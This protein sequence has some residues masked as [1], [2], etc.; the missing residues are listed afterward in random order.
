MKKILIAAAVA[1]SL[2]LAACVSTSATMLAGG[3]VMAATDPT[4]VTIYRTAAQV[5]GTYREIALLDS[6][7]DSMG[8]NP[9]QMYTSMREKAAAIGANGVIIDA[10]S[11]PSAGAQVAAMIFRVG[12]AQRR[13]RSIAIIVEGQPIVPAPI[14]ARR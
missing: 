7:G 9:T 8:T 2:G 12:G 11:E 6:V 13:G 10:M 1:A 5:P 3:P 4:S 14:K